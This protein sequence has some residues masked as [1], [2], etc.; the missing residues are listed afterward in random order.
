M[1]RIPALYKR[2]SQFGERHTVLPHARLNGACYETADY[3]A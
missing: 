2:H 1:E 3:N